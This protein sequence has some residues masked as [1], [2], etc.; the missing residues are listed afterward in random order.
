MSP[1]FNEKGRNIAAFLLSVGGASKTLDVGQ[2]GI[3]VG[4]FAVHQ[5][6]FANALH[7]LGAALLAQLG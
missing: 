6:H 3:G 4:V 7:Q 1:N 5:C 2:F